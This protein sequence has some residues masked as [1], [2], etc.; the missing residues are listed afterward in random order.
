[1]AKRGRP[2]TTGANLPKNVHAVKRGAATYYYYQPGRSGK[3]AAPRVALGRDP[4]DPAFWQKIRKLSESAYATVRTDTFSA[5]V[6]AYKASPEWARLRPATKT[7]YGF[8]ISGL[9]KVFGDTPVKDISRREILTM[10]DAMADAISQ[11]NNAVKVLKCLLG[12]AMT[13]EWCD[14]N[15]ARDIPML[16]ADEESGHA[17]WPEEVYAYVM[18]NA[19]ELLRR[20]AFL[21]RACGQ[22]ISDL[23]HICPEMLTSDGIHTQISKLRDKRH[24]VPLLASQMA[25]LRSWVD[26]ELSTDTPFLRSEGGKP[27]SREAISKQWHRWVNEH[28]FV[29]NKGVTIHGLRAT[30]VCDRFGHVTEGQIAKEIG[31]SPKMVTR[32]TRFIDA[33]AAARSSRDSREAAAL[34]KHSGVVKFKKREMA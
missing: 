11:A 30:A 20:M 18:T 13:R 22:R 21:G 32:Y 3:D 10:R 17:P 26:S 2:R 12:W 19:P 6:I 1:M 7:G 15:M 27:L 31:M 5:L 28:P 9:L 25:E 16:K 34:E 14:A 24:F 23:V 8:M 33:E 4:E 29:Q